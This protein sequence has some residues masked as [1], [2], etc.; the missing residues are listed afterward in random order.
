MRLRKT[1]RLA[2]WIACFGILIGGLIS[3]PTKSAHNAPLQDQKQKLE[4]SAGVP[5]ETNLAPCTSSSSITP[6]AVGQTL[7]GQ[8]GA[9]DCTLQDGSFADLYSFS[10]TA[11]QQIAVTLNS[12]DFDAYLLLRSDVTGTSIVEDDNGGG[13]TSARIPLGSGFFSLPA[14]GSYIILANSLTAGQT[15][16]YTLSLTGSNSCTYSLT[17]AS[18]TIGGAGGSGSFTVTTF[19]TTGCNW[20]AVSNANWITTGSSSGGGGTASYTVAANFGSARSG[21]LTVAGQTFTVTQA[22]MNGLFLPGDVFVAITN[23]KVQWRRANGT[24]V[25]TLD[26]TEG[27]I[28]TGMAFDKDANLYATGAAISKVYRFSPAGLLLGTFGSGYNSAP[29]SIL[30]DRAGNVYVG[31][32]SGNRNILKFDSAGTS[33]AT[34]TP[35]R[36]AR[37]TDWIELAED[38]CTMFYTSEGKRIKRF[39]VCTNTQLADFATGLP[40]GAAFALRLLPGGGLIVGDK[41]FIVRLDAAGNVVRTYSV[42][43]ENS[44]FAINLDPDG[45]SFWS[46]G[47]DSGNVYKFDLATGNELLHFNSGAPPDSSGNIIGGLVIFGEI[48]VGG[49][50]SDLAIT[51]TASPNSVAANANLTYT[52]TVTNNGPDP[53]TSVSVTDNLPAGLTFVSCAATGGGICGGTGN[54]RMVSFPPLASGASATVTLVAKV[55]CPATTI[56]NTATVSAP[57]TTDLNPGNN[58][59]TASTSVTGCTGSCPVIG[60]LSPASGAVGSSVSITGLNL[61]GISAVKFSNN[62][63]TTF[64][65]LSDTLMIANVPIG[66]VNG[67]VTLSKSNCPDVQTSTSFT[68]TPNSGGLII[69]TSAADVVANNGACTLREAIINANNNNQSGSTDCAAG[70]G[71][72]TIIFNIPGAGPHTITPTSPLPEI[73]D[74]VIIDATTQ[75]GASC[76]TPGG[77]KIELSGAIAGNAVGVNISAGNSVVR[78]LVI[79]RFAD[80]GIRLHPNG[81]NVVSCNYVGTD[82]A[83]QVDLGNGVQGIQVHSPDNIIGGTTAGAGNLV[84]GNANEGVN[85][86]GYGGNQVLGNFIGTN[87]T[88]TAAIPNRSGVFMNGTSNNVV[89]GATAAARNLISGNDIGVTIFYSSSNLVLGNYIGTDASGTLDL[90][91][92]S[93]GI[94][95]L[96]QNTNV[97][98][99]GGLSAGSGNVISGNDSSG[100]LIGGD[101]NTVTMGTL[102]FG[103][104]IGTNA[105]GTAGI[106][107]S[108][109]GVTILSNTTETSIGGTAGSGNRIAFNA[110]SGVALLQ[111]ST[112][113]ITGIRI[114]GNEIFAN[115]ALGIDL[116]STEIT[117]GMTPNDTGDGDTGPNGLQNFPVLSAATSNGGNTTIAGA[118]NSKAN[119]SFTVQFFSNPVCDSSGNGEGQA[120]LGQ[121]TVTTDANGNA[122][123]NAV[124]P[125]VVANGSFL[126]ATATDPFGNTSEFSPC[127]ALGSTPVRVV[128]IVCPS[129]PQNGTLTL[130]IELV[131]QGN[132]NA[133]GFSLN[134]D[135]AVL[136]NPQVSLG[137]NAASATLSVNTIQAAQGHLGILLALP[138]GQ[139]FPAGARQIAVVTFTIAAN[140]S[141]TSTAVDFGDAPI[142]RQVA[143]ANAQ[144]LTATYQGC[145]AI[146]LQ[147]GLEADV[148]PRPD[149]NGSVSVSDWVQACRFVAGLDTAAAGSEFQRADVAPRET[150]GDGLITVT[151][152]VQAGRY[153]AGLDPAMPAG[154]PTSQSFLN[155]ND[156]RLAKAATAAADGRRL[157]VAG[158]VLPRGGTSAVTIQLDARGNENAAAFSISFDPALLHFVSA[159]LGSDASGALLNVNASQAASGRIGM[160]IALSPGQQMAAGLRSL[161]VL[162]FSAA[163]G[164]NTAMTS[165]SFGDQPIKSQV[166]DVDAFELGVEYLD[167]VIKIAN[168]VSSV[169]AAS[170]A[171]QT[172]AREAIVAAFGQ[173]LAT[174]TQVATTLPLP[175]SLAGTSIM[176]KDSAGQE[177]PAPL[178]FVSPGQANYLIPEAAAAGAAT[179]TI[180]SGNGVVS[181]GSVN[182]TNAAP[183]LF[184][185]NAS[186]QGLPAAA[187]LRIRSDG[188]QSYE[189][190]VQFDAAQNKFVALPIDLGAADDQVFLL[191]FGT[192][193]R[194]RS[195][196]S[197]VSLAVGG[198]NSPVSY[199]GPQ[200]GF[201]G[202]DQINAN[203]PHNLKGRG[204]VEVVLG[205]DG[206]TA[207][208][209]HLVIK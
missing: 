116:S 24:L 194:N 192:G 89:G 61:T 190:V 58:S 34:F 19:P 20:T 125:V 105:A 74:P 50:R 164:G 1:I 90:G 104:Y 27:G 128:R 71:R 60:T 38:Q 87:A 172:L 47:V 162:N 46:A 198:L 165:L 15:G 44:W 180:T 69:V 108:Q 202:L 101:P 39:N 21:T 166:A 84:S 185:V 76:T 127:R 170:F 12:A 32:A 112:P 176:V 163:R 160:T 57:T 134:F 23:G 77:L 179:V 171:G 4:K 158:T 29:E 82:V 9:G 100:I 178:F 8:L 14:T 2:L 11:G 66:A 64:V 83:G 148:A 72:D 142:R 30:F 129:T 153:A 200:S 16:N 135:P 67:P 81:G 205:V 96:G 22:G 37:G 137:S 17:P 150:K 144:T 136:T 197:A 161:V 49:A 175:F 45:T 54:N 121:T 97:N 111:N 114:L 154:G 117:D 167:A 40:G 35:A 65:V 33:L 48:I 41:Q 91:N 182:I 88:G 177:R 13:G 59:A 107:N 146:T 181:V 207:N 199:A 56:S 169:S 139:M 118:L 147:R 31:Q 25:Q 189:S 122:V 28:M 206:V 95:V 109:D 62:V 196:L 53:A 93:I 36:E 188:S 151:D 94:Y 102:V 193:W 183:G 115:G 113:P 119:A 85:L 140:S 173:E 201:A 79:N 78:G 203:L 141:V 131:S 195:S 126:T 55:N 120:F 42:T 103:N 7:T 92:R 174:T 98:Q 186:G 68:V 156:Q 208:T 159:S 138:G 204:D 99:I 110:R 133:L 26:T 155:P 6:I 191:L 63:S 52:M 75:P 187:A 80:D 10:G 143:D 184:T 43:G 124:L 106:P 70:N 209:V 149:G 3:A 51:Q 130:P 5:S 73:T 132:E 152:C 168:S 145:S 123:I 86:I 18:A 157:R